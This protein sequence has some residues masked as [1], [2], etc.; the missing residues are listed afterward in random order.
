M[1]QGWQRPKKVWAREGNGQRRPRQIR[2]IRW[3]RGRSA[4]VKAIDLEK[5]GVRN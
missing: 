1:D 5:K 4:R 3:K 2:S